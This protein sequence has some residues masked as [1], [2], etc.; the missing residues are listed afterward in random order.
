MKPASPALD[1]LLN[2][3]EFVVAD[4]YTFTLVDGT[5]LRFTS[6]DVDVVVDG[7]TYSSGYGSNGPFF[8]RT[9]NKAKCHWKIGVEVD[10]LIFDVI[11]AAHMINGLPFLQACR[12]GLFD[13]AELE[14]AR[15]YLSFPAPATPTGKPGQ[16]DFSD[17]DQSAFIL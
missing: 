17:P 13:G 8:D 6:L 2:S 11:P 9:D 15:T 10:T 3:N 16:L 4:L 1:A 5:V 14:L 7:N 12:L